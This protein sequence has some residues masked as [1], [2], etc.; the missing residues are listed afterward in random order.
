MGELLSAFQDI[1]FEECSRAVRWRTVRD[2][3]RQLADVVRG[4]CGPGEWSTEVSDAIEALALLANVETQREVSLTLNA[5]E[6]DVVVDLALQDSTGELV[7]CPIRSEE[8]LLNELRR[9]PGV[10]EKLA[11][12]IGGY[13]SG[14]RVE[15]VL[16][17]AQ[18]LYHVNG[19]VRQGGFEQASLPLECSGE[20]M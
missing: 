10:G 7:D 5:C 9:L 6:D 8:D 1:D 3:L 17:F 15:H 12:R 2:R 11:V 4:E 16:E 20:V 18:A 14:A 19:D 13:L